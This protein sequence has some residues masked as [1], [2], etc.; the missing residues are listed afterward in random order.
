MK[1]TESAA[2]VSRLQGF[3]GLTPGVGAVVV[4][5]AV[6]QLAI[7]FYRTVSEGHALFPDGRAAGPSPFSPASSSAISSPSDATGGGAA[8]V[9]GP[10]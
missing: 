10:P 8:P 7:G 3:V 2:P 6:V 5:I 1:P 9:P 4:V